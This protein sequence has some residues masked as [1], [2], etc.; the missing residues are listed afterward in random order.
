MSTED[1]NASAT[2]TA[3]GTDAVA[4]ITTAL[5][6][7]TLQELG[8]KVFVGNLSFATKEDQLRSVFASHG[9]IS[10]V[11]IIHRGVRSLGYGFVT[12]ANAEDA[13][14]AVS[15]ADKSEIDGRIINA[16]IAKPAPGT[17]GGAI[18]RAAAKAA[19]ASK[20]TSAGHTND[21]A[22]VGEENKENHTDQPSPTSSKS[23]RS[24]LRG[25]GRFRR[26]GQP[27]RLAGESKP[28]ANGE[29]HGAATD[30]STPP[31][32]D[33]DDKPR[34]KRARGRRGKGTPRSPGAPGRF[35]RRPKRTGPPE[36]EPS[37]TL[38]FV[39]NLPFDVTEEQLKEFFSSYSV[40]SA[41]VI[42]R[43][44]GAGAGRS[45][46]FGFVEF[47]NEEAQLK[48]LQET[49]GKELAGRPL[50]IKIAVNETKKEADELE[51]KIDPALVPVDVNNA[52]A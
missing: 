50:H 23:R 14:K 2:T 32:A 21:E 10:E 15:I 39:A 1:K 44:F 31:E 25:R 42:R 40:T 12:F 38:L 17:P 18:P 51:D 37:K 28:D 3:N 16:E 36:G 30:A 11:Q 48:A 8:R 52:T 27:R 19:K 49:E 26:G 5:E 22:K 6:A 34:S 29:D 35:S 41:H 13:E 9:E 47:E 24:K 45:K 46:G 4:G 33:Q 43:K 20:A 7:S